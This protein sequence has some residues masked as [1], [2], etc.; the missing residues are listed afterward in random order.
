MNKLFIKINTNDD[1][2]VALDFLKSGAILN[3]DG[4]DIVLL[5][6]IPFGH[7]IALRD[8]KAG[9][10][11][12]KF[13]QIIGKA[14]CDIKI[15]QHIHSHNLK[16]NLSAI[17]DYSFV[18]K[19][20]PPFEI[21]PQ[22]K[23]AAFAG[24]NRKDG[25]VGIRNDIWIIPTVGCV[26]NTAKILAQE[27]N[28]E[29]ASYIKEGKIDGFFAYTHTMGC[30]QIGDD[31]KITQ[32]ILAGLIKNPNAGAVLVLGLGCE[33][34]N[35]K[36]FLPALGDFDKDRIKFLTTQEVEDEYK[37][38][39]DIL[40]SLADFASSFKREKISASKLVIGFKCGGSD[41]FSGITANPLCGK[42][43]DIAISLGAKTIL[44]ETPEMF[45]AERLLMNRAKNKLVF[46]NIVAL[47]NNFKNYFLRYKQ[48]IYENPSP[49]NK[50]GGITTLE[51]KS[52]GC[53]QKGGTTQV[54][55]VLNYG[56]SPKESGLCLLNGSGNDMV[57]CTNLTASGA[58]IILFTTGR[59]NPFG[60]PV[61]TVKISSNTNLYERK[62]H[63]IDFNAGEILM[64]Y[65][66]INDIERR[67]FEYILNVASGKIKTKNEINN[68]REIAIFKDGV[69]L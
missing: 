27:A 67:L 21:P 47:I 51:E 62:K 16:T 46:D 26:N 53:I 61:P 29:F 60:A 31:M 7:K 1:V 52:L 20:I 13:G 10:N 45:G 30:S 19:T 40:K 55:G 2:I 9:Q 49:G 33:N 12:V 11:V 24:Y 44:T 57:S 36:N 41:A 25:S 34:N 58:Q 50:E 3:A 6:D 17:E 65:D 32:K 56:E 64:D 48:E 15:G 38:G 35:I 18:Q 42:I 54:S 37:A 14:K 23:T 4:K 43:N 5:D 69:I 68:Y 66:E 59:G 39:L 28:R 63:W 8:I 22:F